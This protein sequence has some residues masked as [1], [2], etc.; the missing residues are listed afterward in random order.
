MASFWK[1]VILVEFRC[2][3]AT[4]LTAL[5]C[6]RCI[7]KMKTSICVEWVKGTWV[8]HFSRTEFIF[9]QQS[10]A[11]VAWF[12]VAFLCWIFI[13]FTM[14]FCVLGMRNSESCG[15]LSN[16]YHS[17]LRVFLSAV[18]TGSV[19]GTEAMFYNVWDTRAVETLAQSQT[20]LV[21]YLILLL[22]R[23]YLSVAFCHNIWL[24][25]SWLLVVL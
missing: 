20:S 24:W 2:C 22:F 16:L 8:V 12:L 6:L 4:V 25:M 17:E 3:Q 1:W 15:R 14:E 11:V 23:L 10:R 19:S 5:G 21:S 7:I 9:W 18:W 13:Y